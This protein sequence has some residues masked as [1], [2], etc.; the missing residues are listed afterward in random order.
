MYVLFVV[1]GVLL[2]M[3]VVSTWLL[4]VVVWCNGCWL[5]MFGGDCMMYVWEWYVGCCWCMM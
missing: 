3:Y 4:M 1:V 5:C 2:V